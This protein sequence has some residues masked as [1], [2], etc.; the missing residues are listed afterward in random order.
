MLATQARLWACGRG[1]VPTPRFGS[2]LLA[3]F[4]SGETYHAHRIL[5]S[6]PSYESHR[7]AWTLLLVGYRCLEQKH[8]SQ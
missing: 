5:M 7:R 1:D 2:R 8:N 6:P 4:Q 3:L